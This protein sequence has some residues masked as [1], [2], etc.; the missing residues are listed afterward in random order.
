MITFRSRLHGLLT[1]PGMTP[2]A[3]FPLAACIL[4][5]V[6]GLSVLAAS[7]PVVEGAWRSYP[8]LATNHLLT[9]GW[10]TLVAL[11]TL[12]QM[13]PAVLGVSSK[14]GRAAVVHFV[15]TAAGVLVVLAGLLAGAPPWVAFG[16]VWLLG[17]VAVFCALLA[18]LVPRRRRWPPSATGV[19]LSVGYLL[20]TVVWG[21]LMALNWNFRFWPALYTY[22]GL[23]V[24]AAV[25]L[26]GWF[27][28]L[29][30]SVSYYLLPRF[31]GVRTVPEERV[32]PLVGLLNLSVGLFVAAAA[33][34]APFLAR[35]ATLVL[36]TA[37][38]VHVLDV[39]RFLR[40]ARQQAPD[41]TNW[42][43]WAMAAQTLLGVATASLWAVDVLPLE[44]RRLAAAMVTWL[45]CGWVTLAIMGHLYKVTPF[46]MWAYRYA[47][48]LSAYE[49]PRL[50]APYFPR[51]GVL[52]FALVAAS[53]SL[54]PAAV[55]LV[56]VRL[57]QAA[58]ALF[59]AG[60]AVYAS[61]MAVSWV[62]AVLVRPPRLQA[63]PA[64]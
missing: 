52:A 50:P 9:L 44:G 7:G 4:L 60:C 3:L 8:L 35:V 56:Q 49:V 46:L 30:V 45:L 27:V 20:V 41:L 53:S 1:L 10:G 22:A 18:R 36:C 38:S 58:G 12:H 16:G 63:G 47:H 54:L 28:Q 37:A 23:G 48:G 24:H 15:F 39:V 13:F 14:P 26:L 19:A 64:P 5:P 17:S 6:G 31:T 21:T 34:G 33:L 42:H 62:V 32:L 61:G 25:G 2:A 11:G 29:V 40:A 43:W 51:W 57:A 55:L 59:A